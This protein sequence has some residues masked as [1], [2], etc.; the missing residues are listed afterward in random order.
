MTIGSVV[1][2]TIVFAQLIAQVVVVLRL[3]RKHG[4]LANGNATPRRGFLDRKAEIERDAR[5]RL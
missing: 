4:P 1:C 2:L 3:D 5:R